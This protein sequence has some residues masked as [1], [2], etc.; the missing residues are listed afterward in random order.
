MLV[1]Q[2]RKLRSINKPLSR[3]FSNFENYSDTS[4]YYDSSRIPVGIDVILS[5]LE[6]PKDAL[7]LDAGAGS[8]NYSFEL[9]KSVKQIVAFEMNEG[10]I[11]QMKSKKE[12]HSISNVDIVQGSLTSPMSE[13]ESLKG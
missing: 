12:K 6:S 11:S 7:V 1:R 3:G 4:S 2:L 10:M 5:Q 13:I 9:C 8:G